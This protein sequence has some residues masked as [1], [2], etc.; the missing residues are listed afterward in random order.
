[1]EFDP[2]SLFGYSNIA[3]IT[4]QVGSIAIFTVSAGHG[5]RFQV[6]QQVVI[7]PAATQP[8]LTNALVARV[9]AVSTDTITVD[10]S[11][12]NREGSSTRTIY[13]GDQIAN[14]A[15][16]KTFT[17]IENSINEVLAISIVL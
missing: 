10:F 5:A 16:P 14:M 2:H 3:T 6:G 17:D 13:I 8:L 7:W 1:M 4:S 12:V 15:T 9:T 11:E